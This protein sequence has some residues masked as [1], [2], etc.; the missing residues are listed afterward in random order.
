MMDLLDAPLRDLK[1]TLFL[2]DGLHGNLANERDLLTTLTS[3]MSTT[4]KQFEKQLEALEIQSAENRKQIQEIIHQEAQQTAHLIAETGCAQFAQMVTSKTD[5][6]F[7]SLEEIS[8][9][10]ASQIHKTQEATSL[11]SRH[12]IPIIV[13]VTLMGGLVGGLLSGTLIRYF[14]P[15][16]DQKLQAQLDAGKIFLDIWPRLSKVERD[17]PM[18]KV[19]GRS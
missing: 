18:A 5:E 11:F 14:I 7:K 12:L 15:P 16:M 10:A 4:F 8:A 17:N 2:L 6:V 1:N 9:R 19:K 3:Q 13:F